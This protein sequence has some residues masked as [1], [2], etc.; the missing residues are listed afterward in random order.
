MISAFVPR[1]QE[2]L[3]QIPG[4]GETKQAAYG[5]EV[6]AITAAFARETQ[7]PLDW[8][9][10]TLDAKMYTKWMFKQ[11]EMKY[12][13]LMDRQQEKRELLRAIAEGKSIEELQ[14]Q[15]DLS[16]RDLMERIEKL[17][18]EG[19]DLE[20][21][22]EKELAQMP[23]AEQ[24]Q[25]WDAMHAIGDRYLR[26]VLHQVYGEEAEKGKGASLDLLY[27]RL[28]LIRL[29]YRRAGGNKVS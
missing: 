25:I 22:I 12:K 4:W 19:Y 10:D 9:A 5:E 27:D 29:R 14:A 11:K 16:R 20:P 13:A 3:L 8:V 2:E 26:P 17:D 1:L 18:T 28:R 7:F 21:L 23:A 15:I 24:Q 6:L